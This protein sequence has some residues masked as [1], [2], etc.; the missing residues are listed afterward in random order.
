[1]L[2]RVCAAAGDGRNFVAQRVTRNSRRMSWSLSG[3]SLQ[4]TEAT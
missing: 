1:V 4:L 2:R 3:A